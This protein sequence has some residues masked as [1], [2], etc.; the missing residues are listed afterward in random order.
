MT[1]YDLRAFL[2]VNPLCGRYKLDWDELAPVVRLWA[3]DARQEVDDLERRIGGTR[4]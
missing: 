2:F 4:P 1:L 3:R